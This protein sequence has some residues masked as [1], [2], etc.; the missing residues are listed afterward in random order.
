MLVTL[1]IALLLQQEPAQT[2]RA[3]DQDNAGASAEAAQSLSRGDFATARD[4]YETILRVHPV[5]AAAQTGEVI[6]SEHLALAARAA[7]DSNAALGDLLRARKFAAANTR[8]LYD[9]GLR[10]LEDELGLYQ[11][12][13]E[14]VSGLLSQS[15]SD[16]KAI[17]LRA[18]IQMDRGQLSEAQTTMAAYL[19]AVPSDA[20][21]HYGMGRIYQLQQNI[22]K[23]KE[24]FQASLDLQPNQT[25]SHYQLADMALKSGDFQQAIRET[26]SV[27]AREPHHAGALT[28]LGIAHYRLKDY[29]ASAQSLSA[30]IAA[31]PGYQTSHYYL[32]LALAKLN[33][34][35]ESDE[36][37]ALAAKMADDDN[38]KAAQRLHVVQ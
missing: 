6:A 22:E 38:K 32:G 35:Q 29:A 21:A 18:R 12:A 16:N 36:Q 8:L 33:R 15:P 7:N 14:A 28:V 19:A 2:T 9:L 25:E 24:Q 5:D 34:K 17:Y 27:L 31:A 11:D 26:G 30:A 37:L 4:L 3:G 20:T 1:V 13:E 10:A 23:A